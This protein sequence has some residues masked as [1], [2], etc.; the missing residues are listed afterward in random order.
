MMTTKRSLI[1]KYKN[2]TNI[3]LNFFFMSVG[4]GFS[5]RFAFLF[6]FRTGPVTKPNIYRI[7]RNELSLRFANGKEG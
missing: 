4:C 3:T 2:V 1:K 7:S 5:K 6:L